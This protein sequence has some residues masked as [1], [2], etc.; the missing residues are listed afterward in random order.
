MYFVR[1]AAAVRGHATHSIGYIDDAVYHPD[2][3]IFP[4]SKTITPG[5]I[6]YQVY[7]RGDGILHHPVIK[8]SIGEPQSR[9]R[10]NKRDDKMAVIVVWE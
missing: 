5:G 6:Q 9:G 7:S 1:R 8:D 10:D 2:D 4:S 3:N